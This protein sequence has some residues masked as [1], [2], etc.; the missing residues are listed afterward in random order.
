MADPAD[1]D[2]DI[3][4]PFAPHW[5]R[6]GA[7]QNGRAAQDRGMA[8]NTRIVGNKPSGTLVAPVVSDDGMVIGEIRMPAP[9][10]PHAALP[11]RRSLL[12]RG[13]YFVGSVVA[14]LAMVY[15]GELLSPSPPN[16]P[17]Q[18][19]PA[20]SQGPRGAATGDPSEPTQRRVDGTPPEPTVSPSKDAVSSASERPTPLTQPPG[21]AAI[22]R[23]R[24]SVGTFEGP[25][26]ATAATQPLAAAKVFSAAP[27]P[28]PSGA[29]TAL[30]PQEPDPSTIDAP[31]PRPRG[32][33]AGAGEG[34]SDP[35]KPKGIA[36]AV[37]GER[38]PSP[39]L[40]KPAAARGIATVAAIASPTGAEGT[41]PAVISAKNAA[42][43]ADPA[44]LAALVGRARAL[45]AAG[46]VAAARLLLRRAA[47]A[48]D[49][50]AAFAL[51]QTY[52]PTIL[53]TMRAFGVKAD[54]AA[55]REWYERAR[56]YGSTEARRRLEVLTNRAQ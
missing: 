26:A 56:E 34:L 29:T 6:R 22:P 37:S 20:A 53:E 24:A 49:A 42:H 21:G 12:L 45:I 46:D 16:E 7:R 3:D 35:P 38:E 25:E 2:S 13:L 17:Q 10:E 5:A 27:E 52:D 55:A 43:H 48:H 54:V 40:E 1:H 15:P 47:E 41:L 19:T 28:G 14:V 39:R 50:S 31:S 9:A 33:I 8:R 4:S 18:I 32:P 36:S 51:G 23:S 44:E 30:K 11:Q